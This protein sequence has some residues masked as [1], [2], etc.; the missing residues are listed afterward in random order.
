MFQV[1]DQELDALGI[2]TVQKE[3][4]HPR[5]SYKMNS[6]CADMLLFASYK[7]N[8]SKPSLL[9]DSKYVCCFFYLILVCPCQQLLAGRLDESLEESAIQVVST[10]IR[11]LPIY[12]RPL[13]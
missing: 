10:S 1:F 2:D 13:I 9:A 6:S 4:I 7:W 11:S 5:K 8:V 3:T 12:V